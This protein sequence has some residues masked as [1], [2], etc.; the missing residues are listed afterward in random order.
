MSLLIVKF[1]KVNAAEITLDYKDLSTDKMYDISLI[2]IR[3]YEKN[4][5]HQKL[6]IGILVKWLIHFGLR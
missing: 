6:Q 3:S 1:K 5:A 2:F 4:T